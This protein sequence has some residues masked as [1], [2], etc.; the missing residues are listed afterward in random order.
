M[1]LSLWI[2]TNIFIKSSMFFICYES[3]VITKNL[4]AIGRWIRMVS[5]IVT[6]AGF[7]DSYRFQI[8]PGPQLLGWLVGVDSE[9]SFGIPSRDVDLHSFFVDPD[10]VV[11]LMWIWIRIQL[12]VKAFKIFN[13]LPYSEFVGVEKDK[14]N[15]SKV[16]TMELVQIYLNKFK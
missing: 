12:I 3:F 9:T 6:V 15:C 1:S 11:I 13:K 5:D 16:T 10:P 14:K 4:K 7:L 2:I 8:S